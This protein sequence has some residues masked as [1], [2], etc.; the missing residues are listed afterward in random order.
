[1][2]CGKSSS[3]SSRAALLF[4]MEGHESK[5]AKNHHQPHLR[6]SFNRGVSCLVHLNQLK[7]LPQL[8]NGFSTRQTIHLSKHVIHDPFRYIHSLPRAD[9]MLKF[10]VCWTAIVT[11]V[12]RDG[13][14]QTSQMMSKHH[15][16]SKLKLLLHFVPRNNM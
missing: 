6:H 12:S 9:D 2:E 1:M 3:N 5:R 10:T 11:V 7:C 15:Q 14:I 13:V 16:I 8:D 4:R